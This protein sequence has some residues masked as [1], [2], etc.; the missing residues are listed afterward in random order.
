MIL[1]KTVKLNLT[2]GT[3]SDDTIQATTTVPKFKDIAKIFDQTD[4]TGD[5]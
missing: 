2:E 1:L 5:F 4:L 3:S